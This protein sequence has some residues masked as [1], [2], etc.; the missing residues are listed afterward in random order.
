MAKEHWNKQI[1]Y[2]VST[3]LL[4]SILSITAPFSFP[5]GTVPITL[6]TFAIYLI[7]GITRKVQGL[8][9]VAIYIAL[10]AI[11]LPIFSSFKGGIGVMIGPTGGFIL[12]YLPCV[13]IISLL[14]SINKKTIWLYP[15][16][17]VA[18][19]I[20]CYL[21]GTIWFMVVMRASFTYAIKICVLPFL[22]FDT[23]KIII[24]SIVS[25]ILNNKT[26][27]NL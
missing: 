26:Q 4:A 21:V 2:I 5:I 17:M 16:S 6:A 10:G 20:I 3:A 24:A 13:L 19:T 14:T 8:L 18:G 27:I 7:G 1:R 15:V 22:L 12:G 9:V 25:Y 23:I 11:G